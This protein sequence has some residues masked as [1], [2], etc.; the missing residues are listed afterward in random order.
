VNNDFDDRITGLADSLAVW[1]GVAVVGAG[2]SARSGL[3]LCGQLSPLL[4]QAFDSDVGAK[5]EL[6]AVLGATALTTKE[7]IGVNETARQTA[8]RLLPA[9]EKARLTFQN[10]SAAPSRPASVFSI[11]PIHT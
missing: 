4:W 2:V 5:A 10:G 1:Y 7:L 3:P 8:L 9:H 6:M 11:A